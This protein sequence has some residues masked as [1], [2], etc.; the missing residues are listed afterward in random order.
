M[1]KP[2]E[3]TWSEY[4]PINKK[5]IEWVPETKIEYIPVEKEHTDYVEV[6]HQID[7]VPIK[8][9]DKKVEYIPVE[10]LEERI[11]YVP[12]HNTYYNG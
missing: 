9:F 3:Q 2:R 6:K 5:H 1:D 10:R 4:I 7:Y 8:Q 12:H 11:E